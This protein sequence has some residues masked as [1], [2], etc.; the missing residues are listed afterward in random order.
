MY[1]KKQKP[2]N[3]TSERGLKLQHYQLMVSDRRYKT[4]PEQLQK[5]SGS[6]KSLTLG[7]TLCATFLELL[8]TEK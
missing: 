1:M 4:I 8:L 3:K 7:Q 5:K 6:T 2:W